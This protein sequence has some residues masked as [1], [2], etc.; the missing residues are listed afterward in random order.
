MTTNPLL[1]CSHSHYDHMGS[2]WQ[3]SERVIHPKEADLIAN[4]TRRTPTLIRC[5]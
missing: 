5:W 3:F 4:P 1:V 2:N